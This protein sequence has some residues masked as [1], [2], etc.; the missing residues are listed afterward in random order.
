[1]KKTQL[2]F[3]PRLLLT[4]LWAVLLVFA[5]TL[6]MLV[7]GRDTL[8][9]AVIALIYLVPVSWSASRW[10]Q[11]AGMSA[12]LTAALTFNFFFI[13]PFYTF[14]IAR[15]EGWLVLIIFLV[16]AI[17]VV[18]RIQASLSQAREAT[19]MYELSSALMIV[20]SE[21]DVARTVARHLKRLYL[22]NQVVVVIRS[23]G[24]SSKI[25]AS[26]PPQI[27]SE[28]RPDRILPVLIAGDP[29]GEIQIWNGGYLEL[30][31][32]N[33]RLFTNFSLQ[34]AR[35]LERIRQVGSASNS[36]DSGISIS[37]S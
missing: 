10:G 22:A 25:V 27:R 11:G 17:V 28:G 1:M 15:I 8:G 32:E 3:T 12:A 6:I 23:T 36:P 2:H 19:F 26:E 5:T 16:V 30:P 24:Q 14:Q 35:A 33:S 21:E 18:G 31:P 13:P 9:E 34:T 7:I 37:E 29:V 4:S 20:N